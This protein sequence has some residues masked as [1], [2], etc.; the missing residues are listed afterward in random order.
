MLHIMMGL[1]SSIA[2]V[3]VELITSLFGFDILYSALVAQLLEHWAAMW[4]VVSSTPA[5]PTLL[6]LK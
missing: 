6:V 5:E 4:E 1:T 2:A 3:S